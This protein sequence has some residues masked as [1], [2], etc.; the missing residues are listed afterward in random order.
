MSKKHFETLALVLLNLKPK[1]K[2][3]K[4][5]QWY[6]HCRELANMCQETNPRFNREKFLATCGYDN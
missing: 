1:K 4:L 5:A 6:C 3:P 2:G